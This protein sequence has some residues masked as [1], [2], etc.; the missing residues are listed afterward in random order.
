MIDI[1]SIEREKIAEL[2]AE[3]KK[4]DIETLDRYGKQVGTQGELQDLKNRRK[5]VKHGP[6]KASDKLKE[7]RK[8]YDA[9][10]AKQTAALSRFFATWNVYADP[11]TSASEIF[12]LLEIHKPLPPW[13]YF[14]QAFAAILEPKAVLNL[15][16]REKELKKLDAEIAVLEAELLEAFPKHSRFRRQGDAR[17]E[18]IQ[19]WI[20][21]QRQVNGPC[22]HKEMKTDLKAGKLGLREK[23]VY[24]NLSKDKRFKQSRSKSARVPLKGF[25]TGI[26]YKV[27]RNSVMR[28]VTDNHKLKTDKNGIK[29]LQAL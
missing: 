12:R 17:A 18:F 16:E 26:T 15:S 24:Q 29:S 14:E 28:L 21:V 23:K 6:L 3:A 13:E 8:F 10:K 4:A 7:F 27:D 1:E 9:Y 2:E 25:S 19:R 11:L 22:N 20:D 5:K